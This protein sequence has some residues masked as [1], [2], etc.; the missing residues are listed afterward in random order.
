VKSTAIHRLRLVSVPEGISWLVLIVCT[1]LKYTTSFNAVPVMGPI[2]GT[3]FILY[4]LFLLDCWK[5][6]SWEPS[7][8]ALLFAQSII[9]AGAFFA[10]RW[11]AQQEETPAEATA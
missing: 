7:R 6:H 11:L 5:K 8:I 9:P 3:L 2:H 4:V 1:V 10:E